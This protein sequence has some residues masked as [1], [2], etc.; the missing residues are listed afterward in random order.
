MSNFVNLLDIVYPV[1]SIYFSSSNIS[2]VNSIGGTWVQIKDAVLA[3]GGSEYSAAIGSFG[4][5][6][7]ITINQMPEHNHDM[8]F[9]I[10]PTT[11][12]LPSNVGNWYCY[13]RKWAWKQEGN[14]SPV[15]NKGGGRTTFRTTI[16]L[17]RGDVL[18]KLFKGVGL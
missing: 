1:G 5:N 15:V 7:A 11:L 9:S 10:A 17:V 18:P 13:D 3:A 2:P 8:H 4:G 12:S 14:D 16:Q 6:K